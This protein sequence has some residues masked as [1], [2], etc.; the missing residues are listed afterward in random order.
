M[1]RCYLGLA[2]LLALL[3]A[4]LGQHA[5]EAAAV[6]AGSRH[7]RSMRSSGARKR[8]TT[9]G[10]GLEGSPWIATPTSSEKTSSM[11]RSL[12]QGPRD[13]C[14]AALEVLPLEPVSRFACHAMQDPWRLQITACEP[15]PTCR[16]LP[17]AQS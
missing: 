10:D 5:V 1:H 9:L 2:P 15:H 17:L 13:A 3:L 11:G 12:L 8:G 4:L 14:G 7:A 6:A 16:C